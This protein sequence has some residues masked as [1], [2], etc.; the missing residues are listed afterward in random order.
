MVAQRR[1]GL[2]PRLPADSD[3]RLTKP[4]MNTLWGAALAASYIIVTLTG[5]HLDE[6]ALSIIPVVNLLATYI[7]LT[8]ATNEGP[9]FFRPLDVGSAIHPLSSRV[10]V[11]LVVILGLETVVYGFP[12]GSSL[13]V[14][15]LG[16]AKALF[17][18]FLIHTVCIGARSALCG[19]YL[20]F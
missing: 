18:Y 1:L 14:L 19:A 8:P 5:W 17:W 10:S 15:V 20:P 11:V 7:T 6:H 9:R 16:L 12:S 3:S 4:A 13:S 2:E